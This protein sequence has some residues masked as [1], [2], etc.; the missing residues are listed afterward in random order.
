M[1]ASLM[2]LR[3]LGSL[4]REGHPK[5]LSFPRPACAGA[6]SDRQLLPSH[7]FQYLRGAEFYRR[8]LGAVSSNL[9]TS[10]LTD[11]ADAWRGT[12]VQTFAFRKSAVYFFV[13]ILD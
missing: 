1:T 13:Q 10:A 12:K 8:R 3:L 7:K 11:F 9:L 6:F 2:H 4:G 5:V